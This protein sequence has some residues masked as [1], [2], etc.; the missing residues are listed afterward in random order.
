MHSDQKY[1]LHLYVVGATPRSTRAIANLRAICKEYLSGR[2]ELEIV[3][4]Y[5]DPARAQVDQVVAAP[6][7]VRRKPPP[8]RRLVG[9]LSHR[10]RVLR[11]LDLAPLQPDVEP[12]P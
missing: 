1:D 2:F 9:D 5:R 7:L 3:D 4:L 10:D 11:G 12:S 6:T 8:V